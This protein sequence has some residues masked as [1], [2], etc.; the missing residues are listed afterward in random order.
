MRGRTLLASLLSLLVVLAAPTVLAQNTTPAEIS[1]WESVRDSKNPAELQAYLDQFP[2]GTFAAL[3]RTRLAA[4]QKPAARASPPSIAPTPVAGEKRTPQAGDTWTYRLSYPRLRG[5][6]GQPRRPPAL[7]AVTLNTIGSDRIDDTLS[8]DGGTS[9]FRAHEPRPTLLVQ[10]AAILSPYLP[11]LQ[12]LPATGRLPAITVRDCSANFFCEAKG[13]VA[14]T[15]VVDVP[16]GKFL[17]TKVVIDQEW[18]WA[19]A[20]FARLSGGRT[21]TVWYAPEISRAVKYSSRVT[22]GEQPPFEANFDLELVS[23]QLK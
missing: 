3:A 10:G 2:N 9:I 12:D 19:Q 16:A 14:G 15:E 13:R 21:L 8:V 4:L 22:V 20:G 6:W 5:Q 1:F 23:Y 11:V 18:R 7:H 17:A